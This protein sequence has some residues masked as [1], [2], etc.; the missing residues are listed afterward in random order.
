MASGSSRV[1]IRPGMQMMFA[2][3]SC[4]IVL[5]ESMEN[6]TPARILLNLLAAIHTPSAFPHDRIPS[7]SGFSVIARA[8]ADAYGG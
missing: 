1:L 6:P 4:R 3:S 2:L 5:A 7:A 8:T